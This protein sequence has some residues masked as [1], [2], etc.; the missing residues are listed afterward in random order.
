MSA[1]EVDEFIQNGIDQTLDK[2][3][4]ENPD[5]IICVGDFNDKYELGW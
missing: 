4:Y 1:L 3:L 5:M 2:V